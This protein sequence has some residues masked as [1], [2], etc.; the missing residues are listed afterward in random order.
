MPF[1]K[2]K[3]GNPAGRP[4]GSPNKAT[5]DI[6]NMILRVAKEL[7]RSP[8][9]SLKAMAQK[10]PQWFYERIL[11]MCLPKN[12]EIFTESTEKHEHDLGP[13]TRKL[14]NRL[15]KQRKK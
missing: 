14:L 3:S 4:K 7:Q 8:K 15:Y 1:K 12:L 2:G 11:R 10:D 6:I 13:E 5:R 9:T